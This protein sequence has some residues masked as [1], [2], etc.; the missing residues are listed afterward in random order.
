[1]KK[2][3]RTHRSGVPARTSPSASAAPSD[4]RKNN[5]DLDKLMFSVDGFMDRILWHAA[6]LFACILTVLLPVKF[7]SFVSAPEGGALYWSDPLSLV[8][9]AWPLPV[10]MM[11]SPVLLAVTVC[12]ALFRNPNR[13]I[14]GERNE[15]ILFSLPWELSLR[16][17]LVKYGA[18]WCILGGVSVLGLVN[19]SC[20]GYPPQMIAHTLSL[21]C[22]A[23]SLAILLSGHREFAKALTGSLVL[24]GVLSLCSGM[25]QYWRGFDALREHVRKQSAAAGRDIL[26]DGMEVRIREGRVQADFN[27]CNVYGAYLAALLPFLTV[28]FWRFGNER[29]SPPKLSRRLFG[30]LV[31]AVTLFLLVKTDSRGAVF[32]LLAACAAVF[33]LSRLPRKWKLAGAGLLFLGVAGLVA[34]VAFGRGALS[35]YVRFDYVQSAARVMLKHPLTGTGW[36]DFLHDH[37]IFRLWRDKEASHSPH[38]M[39]MLFGSQCGIAGFLAALAVLAYPVVEACRQI[40]RTDW[41][42]LKE[43]FALVPAFSCL[44]LSAGTLLDIGFETTA[45]SGVLIAFSLLVL[46]RDMQPSLR[47]WMQPGWRKRPEDVKALV[48]PSLLAF[49]LPALLFMFVSFGAAAEC[50]QAEKTYSKL[51]A[52]LNPEYS[53]EHQ[54]DLGYVPPLNRVQYLLREAV[55][56]APGSPFPWNAAA[57]YMFRI[58]E[59]KKAMTCLNQTIELDPLQSSHYVKRARMNWWIAGMNVTDAVKKDLETARR[60]APKNPELNR[61]DADICRAAFT[62]KEP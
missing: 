38:N 14:D 9:I 22:Y 11:A 37:A 15:D 31:F 47:P 57:D 43:V 51:I 12:A 60:L 8:F 7:A 49:A 34:M 61:P 1:M 39:V 10:F 4:S 19:A 54:N 25:D 2:P 28:L 44:I 17:P 50:F 26:A 6:E 33:F 53:F 36:G 56:A 32:S 23:L 5:F 41:R 29:V 21:A 45:Y 24:G 46:M 16:S 20:M 52:E 35:M 62:P 58:G 55:K 42:R 48:A 27:S 13:D 3:I 30:G 59:T 18:L 40:R